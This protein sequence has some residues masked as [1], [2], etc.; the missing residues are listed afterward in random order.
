MRMHRH[1]QGIILIEALIGILIFSMGILALVAMQAAAISA[2]ADAQYRI[3]AANAANK[4]LSEIWLKTPRLVN[5]QMDTAVLNT[6]AHQPAG[7]NCGFSGGA[8]GNAAVTAWVAEL[9]AAGTGL[10]GSTPQ[11]QQI[12]VDTGTFNRVTITVCWKAPSDTVTRK[13]QVI[14]HVN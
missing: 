12:I 2:Q 10:P 1:Q 4:I 9:M 6:F 13:H 5:G 11:M 7:Q 3:E 8:S 14:S